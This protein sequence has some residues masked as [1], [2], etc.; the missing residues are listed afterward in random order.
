MS[1][2][3][4]IQFERSE[5]SLFRNLA[6]LGQKAGVRETQL[7]LLAI[8]ELADN[9]LD[10]G[11]KV[12]FSHEEKIAWVIDNGPGI[13]GSDAEIA[14][15][16]SIGR[17]LRSSKLLRRPTRGALGNG[18]RVVVGLVLA[19][20]GRLVVRTRGRGLASQP[21]RQRR[22]AHTRAQA[23]EGEGHTGWRLLREGS[24]EPRPRR[25]IRLGQDRRGTCGR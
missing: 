10:A 21:R 7:P 3:Q 8:K 18:I 25:P 2:A 23:V 4:V 14:S 17:P 22:Y 20:D 24:L 6:T 5:I 19:S 13:N 16:F 9:A 11:A 15:L 1:A 12:S